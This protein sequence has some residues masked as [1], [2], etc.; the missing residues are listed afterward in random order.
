MTLRTLALVSGVYDL[1]IAA[2]MLLAPEALARLFGA[3]P[4][5]PVLNA[6]LNGVFA[7]ALAAG[8]F[9]AAGDAEARRGYLWAAGVLAKGL[10][11]AVFVADH[12]T[13]G[14][15]ASFLLFAATDGALAVLTLALLRRR[16]G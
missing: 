10:G 12:F 7:L 13:R 1:M 16:A 14:S 6:Q 3:A 9:W 11:A 5:V 8:Y 4:P 15:P 2:P